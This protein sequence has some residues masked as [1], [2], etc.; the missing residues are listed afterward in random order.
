MR[1][2]LII[3]AITVIV[4]CT[5]SGVSQA[6]HP[7]PSVCVITV[8]GTIDPATAGYIKR[9][10]RKANRDNNNL[11]LIEL[12]TPGGLV[13]AT[14][15]IIEQ[16][17][18]SRVPIAVYVTPQGAMASSAGTYITV[19]AQIAAMAPTTHIGSATPISSSGKD[20]EHKVTN[21]LASYMK[22]LAERRGRNADWAIKAV[23]QG[24]SATENE[25]LKLKVI[26][27][28]VPD[29][30]SL[31]RAV[32]GRKVQTSGGD[33]V[34]RSR[35]A[36]VLKLPMTPQEGF[37][38]FLAN[39]NV[40]GFLVLLTIY[41]LIG[42]VSNPGAILPGVVG[43]MSLILVL[44]SSN[45]LPLSVT[46][47]LLILFAVVLFLIDTQVTTHGVLTAGGVVSMALGLFLLVDAEDPVYRMSIPF[48]ASAALVTGAFFVFAVGAGIRAQRR[49]VTTGHEGLVGSVVMAKT[50]IDPVGRVFLNGA[51]WTAQTREGSVRAG[52][53]VRV[54]SVEG[55]RLFVT[56]DKD[57]ED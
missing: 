15:D 30:Q 21:A 24:I 26:D 17:L 12:D 16:M 44:Y 51:W 20:L 22:T 40:I 38:H 1:N 43:G 18:A 55:L 32:D 42:E 31:F 27:F 7:S 56:E 23:R 13:D 36:D 2:R 50:D 6:E 47:L 45:L 49:K 34:I 33:V 3:L 5:L 10:I 39:P 29:R 53:A 48:V 41:G 9:G 8:T 25:A 46:G 37:M 19:A 11:L 4:V 54:V 35:G 52:T 28:V 14:K 57:Q